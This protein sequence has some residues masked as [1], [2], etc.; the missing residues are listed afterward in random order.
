M[1]APPLALYVLLLVVSF[2]PSSTQERD[3]NPG[4]NRTQ[5]E[6]VTPKQSLGASNFVYQPTVKTTEQQYDPYADRLYRA[7]LWGTIVAAV[8]SLIVIAMLVWQNIL[9]RQ[10]AHAAEGSAGAIRNAE[11]AWLMVDLT[12]TPGYGGYRQGNSLADITL[13]CRNDGATPCWIQGVKSAVVII[14]RSVT[15]PDVE[16]STQTV[17]TGPMPV[18][19]GKESDPISFTLDISESPGPGEHVVVYGIVKYRQPFAKELGT[20]TFAYASEGGPWKRRYGHP[21]YN[22]HT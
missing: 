11:R 2:D 20:T 22:D 8:F 19:V 16:T 15:P 4:D 18:G 3:R 5:K 7:Y 6:S 1:Y 12:S 9:T 13:K 10:V 14:E 17:F 21:K